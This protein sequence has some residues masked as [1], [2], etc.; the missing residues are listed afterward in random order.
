MQLFKSGIVKS[1]KAVEILRFEYIHNVEKEEEVERMSSSLKNLKQ[2]RKKMEGNL[3]SL[4]ENVNDLRQEKES[5][6]KVNNQ[7]DFKE[8]R[9]CLRVQT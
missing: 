4:E 1:C 7:V 2:E 8:A 3:V 6:E 9:E 5:L